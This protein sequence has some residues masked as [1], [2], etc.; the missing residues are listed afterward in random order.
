[1]IFSNYRLLIIFFI[2]FQQSNV[3]AQ[4][5]FNCLLKVTSLESKYVPLIGFEGTRDL[6]INV[7]VYQDN[8]VQVSGMGHVDAIYP[9]A[10]I[11]DT[12][13]EFSGLLRFSDEK[14]RS[15]YVEKVISGF[16]NRYS[17]SF[18]IYTPKDNMGFVTFS[19]KG[20]CTK[21][22]KLF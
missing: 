12:G 1:M 9:P 3:Q 4:S 19:G 17:G 10:R 18:E 6:N 20:V 11:S 8:R 16:L 21:A 13:I 5:V 2:L 22:N 7:T 15:Y 14:V